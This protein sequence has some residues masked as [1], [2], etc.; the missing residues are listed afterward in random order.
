MLTLLAYASMPLKY[1]DEAIRTI[2][3]LIYKLSLFVLKGKVPVEVLYHQKP[4]YSMLRVFD[5]FCYPNLQPYNPYEFSFRTTKY[6][7]LG[8]S[9]NRK[10][11]KCLDS[12]G[13]IFIS[14]DVKFDEFS[15]PFVILLPT[16]PKM[17]S[18]SSSTPSVLI[19]TSPLS[20]FECLA[21]YN[22]IL[23][24]PKNSNSITESPT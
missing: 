17:A 6:T 23:S 21:P 5:C 3:F 19:P 16:S 1:W 12:N 11:F 13:R 8:Y 18:S 14:R 2:V 10:G 4:D 24:L 22:T 20:S 7:F 15:C 9:L